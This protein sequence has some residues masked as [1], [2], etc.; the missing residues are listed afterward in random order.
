[1]ALMIVPVF[2]VSSVEQASPKAAAPMQI[3]ATP[4]VTMTTA[5]PT[6]PATIIVAKVYFAAGATALPVESIKQIDDAAAAAKKSPAAKVVISGF[7]DATGSAEKNAEIAKERA[8]A[9]REA[10]KTVGVAEDRIEMMKP[11]VVQGSG[12]NAEARRVEIGI[13]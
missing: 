5:A 1:M 2:G 10:L 4:S 9:V 7:H 12:D 8:K 11:E 6:V 3:E 13:K